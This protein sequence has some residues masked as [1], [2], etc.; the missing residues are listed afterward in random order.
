[1]RRAAMVWCGVSAGLLIVFAAASLSGNAW[2][3]RLGASMGALLAAFAVL[4]FLDRRL[5]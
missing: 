3:I 1:M 5:R 2:A 4:D